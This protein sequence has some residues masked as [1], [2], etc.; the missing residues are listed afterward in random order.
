MPALVLHLV[1]LSVPLNSFLQTLSSTDLK[2]VTV[3][4]PH[5]WII[6]PTSTSTALLTK[7][8]DLLLILPTSDTSLPPKLQE[9]ITAQWTIT[10]GMPSALFKDYDKKNARL[11]HPAPGDVPPLTGSLDEGNRQ[12]ADSA[13]SLALDSELLN[14]VESFS[15][16]GSEGKDK[17]VSML[18][19]L[20]FKE[21]MHESYL[22]YGKAFSESVG[23]RRG[24]LAKIVGKVITVLGFG[25][26][27]DTKW[28]EM[29]LAHYPSI[30]HFADMLASKD[31]QEANNKHR[32]P[33]LKDTFI[34]C[35]T[36]VVDI[37]A[38]SDSK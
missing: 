18:N 29:T 33:A 10:F 7:N 34:L 1:T 2:P 27:G 11:Q 35:T 5:R 21:G 23:S 36:E 32:V 15:K 14:W 20:A 8:W 12:I 3:A 16:D 6:R 22:R 38:Q 26:K 28:D 25:E 37:P 30:W 13:Q 17:A 9:L 19:L 24:G 4:K 31:Y